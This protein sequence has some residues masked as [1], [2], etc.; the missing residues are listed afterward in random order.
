MTKMNIKTGDQVIVTTGK[1]AD[2]KGKVLQT[3]PKLSR[4]VVE[5]V[6]LTKRHL[7]SRQTGVKGQTVEFPMPIHVSNVQLVGA[8]GKPMR[9]TKRPK[10]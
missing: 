2:K 1:H 8:D 10:T 3:F 9:H 5:G 7:K 6:N 4:V